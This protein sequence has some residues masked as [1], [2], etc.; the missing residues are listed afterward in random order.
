[1]TAIPGKLKKYLTTITP[2]EHEGK[3]ALYQELKE[4]AQKND[5]QSPGF[6]A[7]RQVI[8]ER[9]R[10]EIDRKIDKRIRQKNSE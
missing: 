1:M 7:M 4:I 2:E 6:W 3:L 9:D 5:F 8:S 10:S